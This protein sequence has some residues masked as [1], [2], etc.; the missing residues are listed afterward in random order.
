MHLPHL[1]LLLSLAAAA[2]ATN[3]S[4]YWFEQQRHGFSFRSVASF[5]AKGD[6]IAD[7]TLAI[8]EAIDSCHAAGGGRVWLL[9]YL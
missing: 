7:D 3:C 8:Q 9:D 2:A 6:G 5:G 4:S 1:S